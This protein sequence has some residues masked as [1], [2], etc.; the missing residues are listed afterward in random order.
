[1]TTSSMFYKDGKN[2]GHAHPL[3]EWSFAGYSDDDN[4]EAAKVL[5]YYLEHK[6]S[7]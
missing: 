6:N 1:M 4:C 5:E 2:T 3:I 7:K